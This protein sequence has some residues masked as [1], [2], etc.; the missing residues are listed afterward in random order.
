MNKAL[1]A[2]KRMLS[3]GRHG[4]PA[5]SP[6][7]GSL[8]GGAPLVVEELDLQKLGLYTDE[9]KAVLVCAG[10]PEDDFFPAHEPPKMMGKWGYGY[11]ARRSDEGVK[12]RIFQDSEIKL[13]KLLKKD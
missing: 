7:P 11:W 8:I 3:Y 4:A 5:Y 6:A 2:L 1:R 10:A 12:W 9:Q 13:H